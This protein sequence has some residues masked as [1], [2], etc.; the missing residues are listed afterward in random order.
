[1]KELARVL[2]KDGSLLFVVPVGK[3]KIA[4]NAHR[5]YSYEEI[6]D[7]FSGLELKDF[8][9]VPDNFKKSGLI[10]NAD[11]ELVKNQDW[12]CGCFWFVKK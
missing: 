8:S 5:V 12:G 11:P 6:I 4:F 9:L 3:P 7:R 2:A 10:H 1:M